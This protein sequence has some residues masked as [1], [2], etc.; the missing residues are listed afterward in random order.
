MNTQPRCSFCG[1]AGPTID[2]RGAACGHLDDVA[3]E[4]TFRCVSPEDVA[5]GQRLDAAR[6]WQVVCEDGQVRHHD[7]FATLEEAS[8]FAWF[9]HIC[10]ARHE[11]VEVY[12]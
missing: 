1:T 5:E 11:Y 4:G 3:L 10:T 2:G 6:R 9:G 8:S 12:P 7:T